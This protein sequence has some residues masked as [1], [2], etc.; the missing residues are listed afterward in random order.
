MSGIRLYMDLANVRSSSGAYN[1]SVT[2]PAHGAV[3]DCDTL[4]RSRIHSDTGTRRT[5]APGSTGASAD[6]GANDAKTIQIKLDV[7]NQ[8]QNSP[9]VCI[10]HGK[11]SGQPVASRLADNDGESVS[12]AAQA[13]GTGGSV[14]VD[15][16]SSICGECG[17][18]KHQWGEVNLPPEVRQTVKTQFAVR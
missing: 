10:R 8:D 3:H 14:L 18:C 1:C 17:G 9:G 16:H 5:A 15:E 13:K 11:I 7:V 12:S 4:L 6:R 2:H